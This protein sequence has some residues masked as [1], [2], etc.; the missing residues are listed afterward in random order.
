MA[1]TQKI[2]TPSWSQ[3]QDRMITQLQ[4]QNNELR[5]DFT[6]M[7]ERLELFVTN[8][9]NQQLLQT[10]NLLEI[11]WKT[12]LDSF[13][14]T[15]QKSID[16][17]HI[18][19]IFSILPHSPQLH[20]SQIEARL[21]AHTAKVSKSYEYLKFQL[22]G[23]IN[24]SKMLM[25][26]LDDLICECTSEDEIQENSSIFPSEPDVSTALLNSSTPDV[27]QTTPLHVSDSHSPN[28]DTNSSSLHVNHTIQTNIP[29]SDESDHSPPSEHELLN[30]PILTDDHPSGHS[31]P[32]P[33]NSYSAPTHS[34]AA[35]L[36]RL[37]EGQLKAFAQKQ[38][39]DYEELV[40]CILDLDAAVSQLQDTVQAHP[41]SPHP[42]SQGVTEQPPS[43]SSSPSDSPPQNSFSLSSS[44]SSS[45]ASPPTIIPSPP[46]FTINSNNTNTSEMS[47]LSEI[48]KQQKML[49]EQ[50]EKL[51][52]ELKT[53][54]EERER[55]ASILSEH[56][57]EWRRQTDE[58]AEK[59][60]T[61]EAEL[62]ITRERM[63]EQM[64]YTVTQEQ[65]AQMGTSRK[66]TE[67]KLNT[68]IDQCNSAVQS[69][70]QRMNRSVNDW[71][72]EIN[73]LQTVSLQT[74]ADVETLWR[75]GEASQAE[76]IAM[77][78]RIEGIERHI[79][80][81]YETA[82]IRRD[83]TTHNTP[84]IQTQMMTHSA[85]PKEQNHKTEES[86]PDIPHIN[87][88]KEQ[89]DHK[90]QVLGS[91]TLH[92][93]EEEEA[94]NGKLTPSTNDDDRDMRT[95]LTHHME[96]QDELE[97]KEEEEEEEEEKE[98]GIHG[99]GEGEAD[100]EE[101]G[102]NGGEQQQIERI[103][104]SKDEREDADGEKGVD[105]LVISTVEEEDGVFRVDIDSYT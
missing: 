51:T 62:D 3:Y 87:R 25:Q 94:E 77:K 97:V 74:S 93:G 78:E 104:Q 54:R 16:V 105:N 46:S 61:K 27:Q 26:E 86:K 91:K 15:F 32:N 6:E 44:P 66:E 22:E 2:E 67:K 98:Q 30:T 79:Q 69:I 41:S 21:S 18:Y 100:R 65:L 35:S 84:H 12:R 80:A 24:Q 85:T 5:S 88:N 101:T 8:T 14:S 57:E 11:K 50:I 4:T 89:T 7:R 38:R 23:H 43:L 9:V 73:A 59:Q 55:L 52:E 83:H 19:L 75:A 36:R 53:E 82:V 47:S 17:C 56:T 48:G 31:P 49:E 10:S 39:R 76:L 68:R 34:K 13:Q 28:S 81:I 71:K 96:Y 20:M 70:E 37:I 29:N 40:R 90:V 92:M 60:K 103:K 63:R 95:V 33:S 72:N 1:S 102:D 64:K 45:Q 58:E 99:E 42:E